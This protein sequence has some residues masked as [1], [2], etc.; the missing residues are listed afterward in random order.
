MRVS[1]AALVLLSACTS[2]EL[3]TAK[4]DFAAGCADWQ[5]ARNLVELAT[6]P[7]PYA[8]TIEL[9][10]SDACDA[11]STL[12]ANPTPDDATWIKTSAS[13]LRNSLF[14]SP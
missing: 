1:L 6:S 13:N 12:A 11:G 14:P 3:S 10:V 4:A 5:A 2:T 7:V 9:Y 8:A